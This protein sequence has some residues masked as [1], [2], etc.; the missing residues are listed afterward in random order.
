MKTSRPGLDLR[1]GTSGYDYPEWKG[2]FYPSGL[3]RKDFLGFYSERFDTLEINY[4]YYDQPRVEVFEG[5]LGRLRRPVDFAVKACRCLTH[6]RDTR[7]LSATAREFRAG[8]DPLIRTGSLAAVL[9]EFPSSFHYSPRERLY[10]ARLLDELEGLPLVVELRNAEWYCARVLE[11][12]RAR[13]VGLCI[14]DAP[15]LPGLPPILD[16]VTGEIAYV[17]FHGRNT[18]AWW[19]GDAGSRYEYLYSCEE[20]AGWI[21]RLGS[22]GDQAGKIRVYFNNHRRGNAAANACDLA[23]I[24]TSSRLLED[25]LRWAPEPSCM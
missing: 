25:G 14:L 12:L 23:R 18:A 11:A 20:L 16:L 19:T 8:L 13:N 17:R 15:R 5:M 3:A 1:I 7:T 2:S 22:L 6:E 9:L 4:T 24:V 10:L 21:P